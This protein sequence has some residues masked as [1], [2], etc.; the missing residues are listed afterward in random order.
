MRGASLVHRSKLTKS[1]R[2][3]IVANID[4]GIIAYQPTQTELAK[5]LG[6]SLPMV[7]RAKRLSPLARQQVMK[8]M[9]TLGYF[10]W[11]RAL[12]KP[13]AVGAAQ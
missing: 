8:G 9:L 4:D 11:M 2:A 1:Q 10:S 6:V 3:V 7:Q 13:A 12:P 5:M